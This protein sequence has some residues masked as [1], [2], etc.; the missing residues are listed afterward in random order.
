MQKVPITAET[1]RC[2]CG[3]FLVPCHNHANGQDFMG[4]TSYHDLQP[5]KH[6]SYPLTLPASSG[7]CAADGVFQ[8][9]RGSGGKTYGTEE[10]SKTKETRRRER[11]ALNFKHTLRKIRNET[12]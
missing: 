8:G 3:G 10:A 9:G 11:Q 5:Y 1:P 4:C 2:T 12:T 6:V 7:S